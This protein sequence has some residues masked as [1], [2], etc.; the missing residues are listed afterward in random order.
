M[1]IIENCPGFWIIKHE[2]GDVVCSTREKV[3][4]ERVLLAMNQSYRIKLEDEDSTFIQHTERIARE[5]GY[6]WE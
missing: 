3:W 5:A 2:S 4:A 1:F 6:N